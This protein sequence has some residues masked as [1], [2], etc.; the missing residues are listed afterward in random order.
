[1]LERYHNLQTDKARIKQSQYA[2][3]QGRPLYDSW[4][5]DTSWTKLW[6][7]KLKRDFFT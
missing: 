1:M 7:V 6:E 2:V 3:S 5:Q 4:M